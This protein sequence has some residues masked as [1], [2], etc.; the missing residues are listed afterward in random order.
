MKRL[1]LV[2]TLFFTFAS[3]SGCPITP[4]PPPDGAPPAATCADVC[5]R[6]AALGC[7]WATPTPAGA[8]CTDVCANA[9][10]F[11]GWN[12]GCRAGAAT[13]E[14]VDRCER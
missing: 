5:A 11:A 1:L 7:P 6:G 9:A 13:C 10:G 4:T 14:A 2:L 12:L 3:C 8:P